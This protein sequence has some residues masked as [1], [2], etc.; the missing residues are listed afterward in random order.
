MVSCNNESSNDSNNDV[1]RALAARLENLE[2]RNFQTCVVLWLAANGYRRIR[3]LSRYHRRGRRQNGGADFLAD[4]PVLFR[5]TVAVQIRHWRT[6]VQRR[7]VDELRGFLLTNGFPTGLI[8]ASCRFSAK[9]RQEARSFSG[10]PI[11]LVDV[12][13]LAGSMAR[14]DLG[15]RRLFRT[16]T[17]DEGFFW[18]LSQVRLGVPA[19]LRIT[20]LSN[21]AHSSVGKQQTPH[22]S[23][24]SQVE[25]TISVYEALVAFALVLL[26]VAAIVWIVVYGGS[27]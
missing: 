15:A 22:P 10:R 16:E 9:A 26:V 4:P 6:P 8:V 23:C 11:E 3:S 24:S 7:A 2:F 20:R 13:Q 5:P 19:S 21:R 18:T 1:S 17:L 14:L 12:W 27:L 25:R